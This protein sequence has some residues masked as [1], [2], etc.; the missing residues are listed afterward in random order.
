M[1]TPLELSFRNMEPSEA[2]EAQVR[3]K[4]EKLERYYDKITSCHVV[5]EASHKR[6]HKGN[7]YQVRIRLN[8]PEGE[9]VVSRGHE[10]NH[11]H[12]DVYVAMRDSFDAMRRQLEDYSRKQRG[13]VK[14]RA[15][16]E[17]A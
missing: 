10:E 11:A 15:I 9:L 12:E 17:S 8:V 4:V 3:E 1:Q 2:V 6:H 14:S 13:D 16:P 7:C 5:I